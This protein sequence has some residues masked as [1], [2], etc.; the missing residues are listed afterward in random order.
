MDDPATWAVVLGVILLA[1]W[2]LKKRGG[3][4]CAACAGAP[5]VS[6]AVALAPCGGDYV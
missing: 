4:C 6:P 5:A 1:S 3:A 2:L